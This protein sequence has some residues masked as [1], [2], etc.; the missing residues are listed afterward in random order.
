MKQWLKDGLPLLLP[1]F[2]ARREIN[3]SWC[4]LTWLTAK[5]RSV[6]FSSQLIKICVFGGGS[7]LAQPKTKQ[8][9]KPTT[10]KPEYFP[11][12]KAKRIGSTQKN[13]SP[14]TLVFSP[15][16]VYK[17]ARISSSTPHRRQCPGCVCSDQPIF[18]CILHM[19][20]TSLECAS[21]SLCIQG[22]RVSCSVHAGAI[23]VPELRAVTYMA[24]SC[25]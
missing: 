18:C 10:P 19:A 11:T 1:Y 9:K 21:S 22:L 2:L 3:V 6:S 23:N 17:E 14:M 12:K 5:S 16:C 24:G 8:N 15:S 25:H 13:S 7:V 4:S 20:F